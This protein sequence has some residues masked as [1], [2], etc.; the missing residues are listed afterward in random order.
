MERTSRVYL[1][2]NAT[3]QVRPEVIEAMLPYL[4]TNYGNPSSIHS[5]GREAKTALDEAREKIA[6]VINSKPREVFFTGS[7]SE[8]DNWAIK[9]VL[10]ANSEVGNHIIT[11]QIEHSAILKTCKFLEEQGFE[12]TYL[13]VDRDGMV[14]LDDLRDA[15]TDRTVLISIM[16]ANNEV[17]SIQPLEE[18]GAIAKEAGVYFHTDAVQSFGK[19]PIDVKEMKV[20]LLSLSGHKIHAPKGIGGLYVRR[21]IPF[22]P[23]IHGGEQERGKRAGTENIPFVVGLGVAAEI[24]LR[25][26]AEE[27]ERLRRLRDKLQNGIE[28][29][30]DHIYINGHPSERL[31][32]TLNVSFERVEGE[33]ILLSLDLKGIAASSGS[34]CTSGTV[35]PSHV[36]LAMGISQQLAQGS[37]RFSLGGDITDEDIDYV[38]ETLPSIMD[39]LRAL[40]PVYDEAVR[41]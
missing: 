5:F 25:N 40:S 18:I 41:R 2:N 12:V 15:I 38:L 13:P 6:A 33:S 14:S 7:G 26:M 11:S 32:G 17:G 16:H 22:D 39:R 21:G 8:S 4:S 29:K 23:L 36:L 37:V 35:E 30:I 28:E 24:S 3:T 34:A 1:D 20:D 10:Y 31:P 19:L 9:G 27:A